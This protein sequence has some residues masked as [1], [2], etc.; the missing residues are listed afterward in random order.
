MLFYMSVLS[1]YTLMMMLQILSIMQ[2]GA[3][4]DIISI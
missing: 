2:F 4:F 1:I 3:P